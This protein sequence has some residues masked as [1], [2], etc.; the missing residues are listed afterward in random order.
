MLCAVESC[1]ED[2]HS[3]PV[4]S[5]RDMNMIGE[6]ARFSTLLPSKKPTGD[7]R[8]LWKISLTAANRPI[9]GNYGKGRKGI[10]HISYWLSRKFNCTDLYEPMERKRKIKSVQNA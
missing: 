3:N 8:L 1:F 5:T 10:F 4:R 9:L 7:L 6:R 2:W